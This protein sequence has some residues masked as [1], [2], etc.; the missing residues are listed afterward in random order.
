VFTL[1]VDAERLQEAVSL[2]EAIKANA[3][4]RIQV[5][6]AQVATLEEAARCTSGVSEQLESTAWQLAQER[7]IKADLQADLK[8][9]QEQLR[10]LFQD[11]EAQ[12]NS[13]SAL[14]SDVAAAMERERAQA[15]ALRSA[16]EEASEISRVAEGLRSELDA[17]RGREA[18]L[19]S[20]LAESV[21]TLEQLRGVLEK[22][23]RRQV[24]LQEDLAAAAAR[25]V[26]AQEALAA[27]RELA[28]E[29]EELIRDMAQQ[30]CT[31]LG[32]QRQMDVLSCTC[33]LEWK[34]VLSCVVVHSYVAR[35][36][37]EI[38]SE[39]KW[40]VKPWTACWF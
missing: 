8:Y 3:E 32:L 24:D 27:E 5:L 1:Q 12:R 29:K 20:R 39:N 35:H 36:A 40:I 26:Q 16:V 19:T 7:A 18:E 4:Q 25:V 38:L 11:A 17:A 14:T 10:I 28:P 6:Q 13:V 30:A 2:S 9:A 22:G 33:L 23:E 21:N 31:C 34:V 37:D 15:A